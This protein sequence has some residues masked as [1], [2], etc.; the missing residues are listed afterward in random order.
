MMPDGRLSIVIVTVEPG[1][2]LV[3]APGARRPAPGVWRLVDH[4]SG[5]KASC[6][7]LDAGNEPTAV[8]ALVARAVVSPSWSGTVTAPRKMVRS[9]GDPVGSV[10]PGGSRGR[11]L[12]DHRPC[13][14]RVRHPGDRARRQSAALSE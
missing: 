1:A 13:P 9:T 11:I 10:V 6:C 5:I 3:P 2:T 7:V 12:G 4:V 14:G 8:S